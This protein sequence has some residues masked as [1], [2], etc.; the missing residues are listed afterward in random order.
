MISLTE[1]EFY[2][3]GDRVLTHLAAC[4]PGYFAIMKAKMDRG[5]E[6]VVWRAVKEVRVDNTAV[7]ASRDY[8]EYC[9]AFIDACETKQGMPF[10]P[11]LEDGDLVPTRELHTI[12]MLC[13]DDRCRFP[14]RPLTHHD[15]GIYLIGA[16]EVNEQNENIARGWIEGRRI[17]WVQ[18]KGTSGSVSYIV[19][20][21]FVMFGRNAPPESEVERFTRK[22]A[23]EK[24]RRD[25]L[26]QA[27]MADAYRAQMNDEMRKRMGQY[28]GEGIQGLGHF[29]QLQTPEP[30]S[31][32]R[33]G[34]PA[35]NQM[36]AQVPFWAQPNL[37]ANLT[38]QPGFVLRGN[39]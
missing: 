12:A 36:P 21:A 35:Y 13:G 25:E 23:E 20:H 24:A 22:Q 6:Q 3:E 18:Q 33:P 28:S 17:R 15:V 9:L 1:P 10:L 5:R 11:W 16:A 30:P 38:P 4:R 26:Q 27:M 32:L 8:T 29:L 34:T 7:P 39:S 31:N 14:E 37:M 19:D 2:D